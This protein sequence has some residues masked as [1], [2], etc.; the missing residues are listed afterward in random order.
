MDNYLFYLLRETNTHTEYLL[1]RIN[2]E[3]YNYVGT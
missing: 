3:K 2:D 1:T